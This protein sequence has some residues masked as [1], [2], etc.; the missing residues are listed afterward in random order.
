MESTAKLD[1]Y[2]KEAR[3]LNVSWEI[4]HNMRSEF[5][6]NF[7]ITLSSWLE[8]SR[9]NVSSG[10]S[11]CRTEL[12]HFI[13]IFEM[14]LNHLLPMKFE[15]AFFYII[16]TYLT[17]LLSTLILLVVHPHQL[18]RKA[19]IRMTLKH[20]CYSKVHAKLH[21]Y[22]KSMN[23]HSHENKNWSRINVELNT[24]ANTMMSLNRRTFVYLE[25]RI[26]ALRATTDRRP[27]GGRIMDMKANC[28]SWKI[29]NRSR[30][31]TFVISIMSRCLYNFQS[32]YVSATDQ[33]RERTGY[34]V[35]PSLVF[36]NIDKTSPNYFWP[37][38]LFVPCDV[39]PL[40]TRSRR[41]L[42]RVR[43]NWINKC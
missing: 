2:Q 37:P 39:P 27:E 6:W 13:Y 26:P 30:A 32:G 36:K 38:S 8:N 1:Q 7:L 21:F 33:I 12:F 20:S 43:T 15:Y 16:E 25:E 41:G 14:H 29:I 17:F 11:T 9:S 40:H 19:L 42:W 22:N 31:S 5:A 28:S 10:V 4:V 18:S 35:F 23:F 34:S 24:V 3:R